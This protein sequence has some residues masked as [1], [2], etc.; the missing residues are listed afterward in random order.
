MAVHVV[1]NKEK[2]LS[3]CMENNVY[4]DLMFY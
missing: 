2:V 3:L 4:D 1:A